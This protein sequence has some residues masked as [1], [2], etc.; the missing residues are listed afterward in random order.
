MI[1]N[2]ILKLAGV[3]EI[4]PIIMEN[5]AIY[6]DQEA[7]GTVKHVLIAAIKF[8]TKELANAESINLK[9][10]YKSITDKLDHILG[11]IKSNSY[12]ELKTQWLS[13]DKQIKNQIVHKIAPK[14]DAYTLVTYFEPDSVDESYS[15]LEYAK[16]PHDRAVSKDI[17]A[18]ELLVHKLAHHQ[19]AD[20]SEEGHDDNDVAVAKVILKLEKIIIDLKKAQHKDETSERKTPDELIHDH[21]SEYEVEKEEGDE[22]ILQKSIGESVELVEE[23]EVEYIEDFLKDQ[24]TAVKK[25]E[26][27]ETTK[28]PAAVIKDI[29]DKIKAIADESK[30]TAHLMTNDVQA[31]ADKYVTEILN[32]LLEYFKVGC[33]YSMKQATIL[34]QSVNSVTRTQIPT[35][36]WKLLSVDLYPSPG[37]NLKD[38]FKEVKI[39]ANR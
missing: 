8:Y 4:T 36:V 3:K 15:L 7:I 6:K 5:V 20:M 18:L 39:A 12:K 38:R 19:A 34:I 29:K 1:T 22:S 21:Q 17:H 35:S 10:E 25:E 28:V 32:Q 23:V 30:Y 14:D 27:E 2:Q 16:D 11:L 33:E 9:H 13:L 37:G 31:A 26:K 24:A